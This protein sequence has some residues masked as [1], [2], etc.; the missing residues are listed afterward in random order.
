M[1]NVIEVCSS[2]PWSTVPLAVAAT[3][4]HDK[5]AIYAQYCASNVFESST[6]TAWWFGQGIYTLSLG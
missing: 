3:T 6:S 2:R 4:E 5:P 1:I